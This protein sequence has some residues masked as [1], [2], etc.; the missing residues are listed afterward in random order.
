MTAHRHLRRE[1]IL[2]QEY[3]EVLP[4]PVYSSIPGESG[5]RV[6]DLGLR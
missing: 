3:V 6:R 1:H 4:T 2:L 5:N